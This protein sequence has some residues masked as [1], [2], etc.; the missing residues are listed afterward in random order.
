MYLFYVDESGDSGRVGS[1]T[2]YFVLSGLVVHETKWRE[3]LNRFVEFRL[4]MRSTFGLLI[5]EEIHAGTMLTRPGPLARIKRNDRL[6]IIRNLLDEI[7]KNSNFNVV[8]VRID[9]QRKPDDYDVF[10]N[11]WRVLIQRFENTL[12][13]KNFPSA[14]EAD[15]GVIFCDETDAT[16]LR[17]LYR[18]MRVFN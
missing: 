16:K 17:S 5:K 12:I 15:H 10:E 8:N 7:A 1:P 18:K 3:A 11:A 6:T 4:K 13:H 9:K 2:R 14:A